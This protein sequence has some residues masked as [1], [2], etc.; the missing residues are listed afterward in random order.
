MGGKREEEGS[1]REG[2]N[3]CI[4]LHN[5]LVR[6]NENR[7]LNNNV[8]FLLLHNSQLSLAMRWSFSFHSIRT[9]TTNIIAKDVVHSSACSLQLLLGWFIIISEWMCRWD[10]FCAMSMGMRDDSLSFVKRENYS[11]SYFIHLDLGSRRRCR[12]FALFAVASS[13]SCLATVCFLYLFSIYTLH[14]EELSL[15]ECVS[16]S[17]GGNIFRWIF[18]QCTL[19]ILSWN[20]KQQSKGGKNGDEK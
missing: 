1:R 3:F 19:H 20:K 2:K 10:V 12:M 15:V 17:E 6:F 13:S 9:C 11:S 5:F 7:L 8:E 14:E 16:L 18:M 4:Q